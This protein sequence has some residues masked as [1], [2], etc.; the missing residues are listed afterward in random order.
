MVQLINKYWKTK[1]N[2]RIVLK[3][4][5]FNNN[6]SFIARKTLYLL[7]KFGNFISHYNSSEIEFCK[8]SGDIKRFSGLKPSSV[9]LVEKYVTKLRTHFQL[10][11][12]TL[13]ML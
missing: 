13:L 11:F 9:K 12:E 7:R 3:L 10:R 6:K 4:V 8:G 1:N 5:Q 2:F